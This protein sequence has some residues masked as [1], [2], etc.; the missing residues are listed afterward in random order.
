MKRFIKWILSFF[1][2]ECNHDFEWSNKD[3]MGGGIVCEA[4][5]KC[6]KCGYRG[7]YSFGHFVYEDQPGY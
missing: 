3:T 5:L 2:K 7:Y 1:K 6:K 4:D